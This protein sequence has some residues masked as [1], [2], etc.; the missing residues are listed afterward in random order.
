MR[1]QEGQTITA[2]PIYADG[3]IYLGVVGADLGTRAFLE[4]MDAETGESVWRYYTIPAPGQPGGDSWPEGTDAYLRGGG[5]VWQAPAYDPDLGLLYFSTGNAG[6]DWDGSVRAGDNKWA[7]SIVAVEADTGTFKWG[8][9]MVHHDIWDLD[10]ASPVVLFNASDDRKGVAQ[11]GKTGWLYM[12]DRET[13]EPLYGIDETPVKQDPVQKTAATQPIPRNGE[14]IPHEFPTP[15]CEIDRI[16]K[17]LTPEQKN[18]KVV[19]QTANY[20][21]PGRDGTLVA[22]M[23]GPQGGV[24]WQPISYNPETNMFYICSAVQTA[25]EMATPGSKWTEGQFY[26]GGVIAGAA[27]TEST[28]TFT[29]IDALSGERK[30]QKEFP[31]ACYSG[32]S[33][34]KGNLVFL[35]RNN[36]ELEAYDARDGNPALELPD[37]GRGEQ[38]RHGLRARRQAVRR[39]PLPGEQPP[40]DRARRRALALRARRHDGPPDRRGRRRGHRAR[41][42]GRPG[43]HRGRRRGRRGRLRGELL[44]LP[45]RA[46]H[47]GQRRSRPLGR[48]RLRSA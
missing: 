18:L 4:A 48:H 37:R 47:R 25:G 27:W 12:L 8:Y 28:G 1:W 41:R 42:P 21:P 40:G 7:V 32:T 38:H 16:T 5:A 35:G 2:A 26:I 36:G 3:K 46:G 34:T 44:R 39:L 14:F 22:F 13:G 6:P 30:W 29:A 10:A 9:Q 11:A 23:P 31:D 43:G 33:T 20:D 24:N 45:R 15:Q 19:P 17:S